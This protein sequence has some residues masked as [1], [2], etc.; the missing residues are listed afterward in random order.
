MTGGFLCKCLVIKAGAAKGIEPQA[1]MPKIPVYARR[2]GQGAVA[3]NHPLAIRGP[4]KK[5]FTG[6]ADAVF[7]IGFRFWSG[8][9]FGEAPTWNESACYIQADATATRIGLHVPAQVALVGDPKLVLRQLSQVARARDWSRHG[10]SD[11]LRE[12]AEVRT[13]FD[14]AIAALEHK[15]HDDAPIHPARVAREICEVI[16]PD[17]TI[18]IDSFTMSGWISQWF[19]ARFPGQI[20]DAGPLAPVGH[21]VGMAIGAQ[22]AR[23]GKQVV[24]VIGDGGLGI[25]GFDLETARRYG[26]PIVAVLWNNSSWGPSFDEMPYL[27]GRTDPFEMLPNQRYD[28]MFELMD[29]YG[30]YVERPEEFRPAL[31][32]AL[33]AGK[34]AL[35][36]VVGDRTIGHPSLGGN[37][38]GS[39]RV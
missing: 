11:W 29:C 22:L 39:T 7:A 25:S 4:W 32:R 24:L 3:E 2:T 28:R 15:H 12:L 37:L 1:S 30:E 27:K 17:A 20:L 38:L 5:P 26:L 13:N 31:E 10:E 21:G 34:T 18:V 19:Q 23:P 8:E 14:R 9:K 35:V 33:T 36:N 16:D 6:R